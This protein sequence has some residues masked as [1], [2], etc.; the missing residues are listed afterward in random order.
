MEYGQ[1]VDLLARKLIRRLPASVLFDDLVQAGHVGALE[2]RSRYREGDAHF[3]T[4][5]SYRIRGAM[6]D[7]LREIDPLSRTQRKAEKAATV[8]T[9][10]IP[11]QLNAEDY[12]EPS[13]D[14]EVP[15]LPGTRQRI[16]KALATLTASEQYILRAEFWLDASQDE[17]ARSL[18]ISPSR[19]CQLRKRALAKLR[20]LL[21]H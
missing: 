19:V 10:V 13:C 1:L 2:A 3:H 6:L 17:A 20:K 4:Y 21:D 11:A 15:E 12:D 7:Y 9:A 5:A 8:W 14:F 16:Q 18:S